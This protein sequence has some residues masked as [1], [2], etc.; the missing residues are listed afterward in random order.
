VSD[1]LATLP[2]VEQVSI[3]ADRSSRTVTFGINDASQYNLEEL[4]QAL[5][6]R[7]RKDIKVLEN[8]TY[9]IATPAPTA[10]R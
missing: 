10:K 7:Y 8:K 6:P 3:K 9:Q 5:S 1:Q 2:W 4:S